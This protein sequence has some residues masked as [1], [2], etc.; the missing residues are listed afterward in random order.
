M[1]SQTKSRARSMTVATRLK[2]GF[3]A[4]TAIT[5]AIGGLATYQLNE[6]SRN[7]N[8]IATDRIP[9]IGQAA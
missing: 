9:K 1:S 5:L 3:G 2:L 6:L 4:V 7:L 8:E